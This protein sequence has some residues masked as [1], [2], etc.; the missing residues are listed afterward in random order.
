VF[1]Y[2][3]PLKS[4]LRVREF[5]LY[6]AVYCGLCHALADTYGAVARN[7]LSYDFAFLAMLLW[8]PGDRAE[9]RAK[10]CF[11]SCAKGRSCVL[12]GPVLTRCAG[13]NVILAR[14]KLL[15]DIKD[16]AAL[17]TLPQ[18]AAVLALR[19]AGNRAGDA[20]PAYESGVRSLLSELSQIEAERAASLDA[21]ADK[22]AKILAA[23][24]GEE[25]E[26]KRGRALEQL[27]Y[28]VGRWIYILDAVQDLR[29]DEKSGG[30]NPVLLCHGRPGEAVKQTLILSQRQAAAA[31][32]LLDEC[33][34]SD[35]SRNILYLG[36]PAVMDAVFDGSWTN[37][38]RCAAEF[39]ITKKEN[40]TK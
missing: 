10:R 20:L 38:T 34:F 28:H 4:E 25:R 13:L 15:D 12:P 31:F 2:I 23:C 7:V 32:E 21:P 19:G 39:N 27:L 36:L 33:V 37:P 29:E 35:I 16:G 6:R 26:I 11:V 17:R 30:Y 9:V 24:S 22:F 8:E 40:N 3:R 1:G 14:N 5:E 18:R